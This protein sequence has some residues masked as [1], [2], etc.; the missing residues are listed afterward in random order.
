MSSENLTTTFP[1]VPNPLLIISSHNHFLHPKIGF[2]SCKRI[3]IIL[4]GVFNG[5][6]MVLMD[7]HHLNN[8]TKSRKKKHC[9]GPVH[10]TPLLCKR[11]KSAFTLDVSDPSIASTN[12]MLA[13]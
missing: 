8:I 11:A 2:F 4:C 13:I 10:F 6:T 9:M 1:A 3:L 12:T 7:G 5:L